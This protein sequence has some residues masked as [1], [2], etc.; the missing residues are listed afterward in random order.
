MALVV[1]L[2]GI[3][4]G[5][6]RTFRPSVLAKQLSDYDVVNVGAAGTFVVRKPGSRAEFRADLLRKLPFEVEVVL[7]EARDLIRLEME[8]PFETTPSRHDIVRFVSVVSKA[9][10]RLASLP[11]TLPPTGPWCVRVIASK[12][13]FVFG[14]YRRQMQTIRYLGQVDKLLGARATTRNWNTIMAIVRILKGEGKKAKGDDPHTS[15][16]RATIRPTKR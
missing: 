14:E 12:K 7:C 1:F 5:G 8:H 2:R 4:V 13:R 3:N 11:R 15:H 10:R 16:R 6:H 9:G